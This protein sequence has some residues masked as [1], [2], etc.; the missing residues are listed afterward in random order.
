MTRRLFLDLGDFRDLVEKDVHA[1]QR[2]HDHGLA[3]VLTLA[4]QAGIDFDVKSLRLMSGWGEWR[5]ACKD[6]AQLALNVR[7]YNWP[8]ARKAAEIFK[9]VNPEGIV[10]AGG[11]HPNVAPWEMEESEAFDHIV[12][13]GG[14]L[15]FVDLV[16]DP[17][18]FPR[19]IRGEQAKDMGSWPLIDRT[20]WPRPD[21]SQRD[22][23]W[24]LEPDCGWAGPGKVA[25]ILT[26]RVCPYVCS[27]CNENS[28]LSSMGRRSVDSL[29]EELNW[30]DDH[31]GPIGSLVIHDSLFLQQPKFL[32]EWLD[33][34]PRKAHKVWSY[35]GAARS[36]L[37]RRWPDL[38]EALVR[39]TNW[40][41]VSIGFESGSDRVL[42]VLNKECSESDNDFSIQ[43]LNRIG[44]DMER[45]GKTPPKFFANIMFAIP[46]ETR[47]DAFKTV[48]MLKSMKRVL[49]SIAYY[50][51]YPGSA[52]GYQI[53]GE[54]KSLM[55]GDYH[56]YPGQEKMTGIDYP[57]YNNLL[58]GAYDHLIDQGAPMS[59]LVRSQGTTGIEQGGGLDKR[60]AFNHRPLAEALTKA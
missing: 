32:R 8:M 25:T 16:S 30:L 47:E 19:L 58:A 3:L 43:L 13:G 20:F 56:R 36:D 18:S 2:W 40:N 54:G 29:I 1:H 24:P 35:W 37:V 27:F 11:I 6:Y 45:Q 42:K 7:S 41:T 17:S 49:P 9:A 33:K 14:E 48:R 46:G 5:M 57:F 44:D 23:T 21:G 50:A 28:F 22:D 12:S 52:L 51:P 34:Y 39:E 15:T 53:I 31:H 55:Q 4:K 38:F 60:E 26:S 59:A 10:M